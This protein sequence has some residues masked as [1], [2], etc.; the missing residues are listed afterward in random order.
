MQLEELDY[1]VYKCVIFSLKIGANNYNILL[2]FPRKNE[3]FTKKKIINLCWNGS[4][5]DPLPIL[6]QITKDFE[7]NGIMR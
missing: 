4:S 5:W 1:G 3:G 7:N 6:H 2:I